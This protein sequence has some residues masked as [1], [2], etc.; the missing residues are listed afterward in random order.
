[1]A[2]P[3]MEWAV[4]RIA[5]DRAAAGVAA[6]YYD[7]KAAR[8]ANPAT[9]LPMPEGISENWIDI[10]GVKA[11]W[12]T[13]A[14]TDASHRIVYFHGG[15]YCA[16][17]YGSHRTLVGWLAHFARAPVLFVE[18][19]L[20]PEHKFP[21]QMDDGWKAYHHAAGHGPDGKATNAER[22]TVAGDSAGGGLAIAVA[23]RARDEKIRAPDAVASLCGMLDFDETTSAF[24][25]MTQRTRD[26][27]K[28]V[29]AWV[30]DLRHPWLSP[31]HG[32]LA[33]LPPL[34][35]Q[36]GTADYCRDDSIRFEARAKQA[37]SAVNLKIW[38]GGIH[39]WHRFAPKVPE[40]NEALRELADFLNTA[41]AT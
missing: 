1:M 30:K 9:D 25:Q 17:H 37:G 2:S 3:E 22:L 28:G 21:A 6:D 12:V 29:V 13:P 35:L 8:A 14:G 24:L 15:G 23:M 11:V 31:V 33:G 18:Y 4:A 32:D 10:D 16:G 36:T 7:P 27:A 41:P 26:M 40:A 5:A 19:R 38:D 39:V 20:A 34:L